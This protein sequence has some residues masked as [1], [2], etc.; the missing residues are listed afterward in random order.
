MVL[1]V[2]YNEQ[3]TNPPM[4]ISNPETNDDIKIDT[5]CF[6]SFSPLFFN[7]TI[8]C[9]RKS[10]LISRKYQFFAMNKINKTTVVKS[11]MLE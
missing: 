10:I 6:M 9:I 2:W 5:F 4:L 1:D 8:L 11:F 3:Y 7:F